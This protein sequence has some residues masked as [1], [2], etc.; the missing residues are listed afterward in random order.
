MK[1]GVQREQLILGIPFFARTYTL[2]EPLKTRPGSPALDY[3]IESEYTQQPGIMAYYEVCTKQKDE[4][5][6]QYRDQS[7]SPYMVKRDQWVGY[8]DVISIKSKVC[9]YYKQYRS[10]LLY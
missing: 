10:D 2:L 7:V 1:N 8:D 4:S 3:G 5:W 6:R 9:K